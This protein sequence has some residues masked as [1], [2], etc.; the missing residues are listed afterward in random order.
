MAINFIKTALTD[1]RVG[2]LTRSSHFVARRVVQE[3][4]PAYRRI[5]EYGPGDG[6]ITKLLLQQLP[7]DGKIL[8]IESNPD[9][10]RGLKN[11][12]DVR[13]QVVEALA[14]EVSKDFAAFGW[15][16]IE[17]VFSGIPF[18]FLNPDLRQ[19]IVDQ[20]Y[21]ALEPGGI[22]LVYQ[23]STLMAPYL[24]KRFK[25]VVVKFEP[26]NFPPYFLMIAKK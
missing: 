26:R 1:Y 18:S 22:F 10:A 15:Q 2:A 4:L 25:K 3:L 9:F 7:A 12:A 11:I 8:A 24:K 5:V 23:Y 16:K 6:A 21:N 20:T 19:R 14:Q 13:L 17:A